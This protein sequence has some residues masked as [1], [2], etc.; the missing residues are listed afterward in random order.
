MMNLDQA[1]T[2]L[3]EAR[4]LAGLASDQFVES[5]NTKS[6]KAE[7][8][9]VDR[10]T[11]EVEPIALLTIDC[12][13]DDRQLILKAPELLR[14]LLA[15]IDA[16]SAKIRSLEPPT[17]RQQGQQEQTPHTEDLARDCGIKCNDR[18][19]RRFLVERHNV[20]DVADNERIAVSV[21]NILRVKSRSHLNTD[22][23]AAARWLEFRAS[24]EAWKSHG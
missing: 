7:I 13:Y 10:L 3:P 12:S 1:R 15:L 8:C 19:F 16:A 20:P 14:A 18:R 6:G 21:R 4:H 17:N 22:P 2:L 23:A 11:G 5:Y 24:F 9:V